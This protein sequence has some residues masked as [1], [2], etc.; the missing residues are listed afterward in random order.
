M[1]T[2]NVKYLIVVILLFTS[3]IMYSQSDSYITYKINDIAITYNNGIN[4]IKN[5]KTGK[6]TFTPDLIT[7]NDINKIK[8]LSDSLISV[9]GENQSNLNISINNISGINIKDGSHLGIG[10]GLG[11]LAG[12]GIG[13]IIAFSGSDDETPVSKEPFGNLFNPVFK[14]MES[15]GK[16]MLGFLSV[17]TGALLGGIIGGNITAYEKYDLNKYKFDK[18]REMERILWIDRK[19]K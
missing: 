2:L 18:K 3:S 1:K 4:R 9:S 17:V 11:A 7:V 15:S 8:F 6:I 5:G 12:L 14:S 13:A 10:I 19:N 16:V